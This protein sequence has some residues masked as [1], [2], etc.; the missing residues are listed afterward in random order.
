MRDVVTCVQDLDLVLKGGTALAFT[1]G[2][3]RHSTDLD[4]DT[5]GAVELRD[6]IDGAA[7]AAG[8][9]LGPTERT[10]WSGHQRFLAP[11][12]N[13]PGLNEAMFFKVNVRFRHPPRIE[14]I[15]VV[16]GIRTYSV[17]ALFDQKLA[18]ASSRVEPR[19]LFDLAFVMRRYGDSLQDEQIRRADALTEDLDRLERRYKRPFEADEVLRELSSI[20]EVVLRF[21][22]AT[23]DQ[24]DRRWPQVQ[25]QRIPIPNLVLGRV[26][27]IQ[28]RARLAAQDGTEPHNRPRANHHGFLPSLRDTPHKPAR[29]RDVDL[30]WPLSR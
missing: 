1:R 24:M 18:A 4:F 21:R 28:N 11:Y 17:P 29:Q 22:Y 7:R 30:D 15:E 14:D 19:D 16:E 20:D 5:N 2:L 25:E 26:F 8:V 13:P 10:D 6:Q 9:S 12:L 23:T 3:N 27:T